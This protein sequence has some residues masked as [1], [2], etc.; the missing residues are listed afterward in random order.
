MSSITVGR[1]SARGRLLFVSSSSAAGPV[2]VSSP[3]FAP[4]AASCY[5]DSHA[6]VTSLP[7]GAY[8]TMRTVGAGTRV[9]D[10]KEHIIRLKDSTRLL[11]PSG[12][13]S[14]PAAAT[15]VTT[16][17]PAENMEELLRLGLREC[18][19]RAIAHEDAHGRQASTQPFK[20]A[21]VDPATVSS[22][23]GAM[24]L[25]A[26]GASSASAASAK[27]ADLAAAREFRLTVVVPVLGAKGTTLPEWAGAEKAEEG[28]LFVHCSELPRPPQSPVSAIVMGHAR[29][30]AA[31]KVRYAFYL[32]IQKKKIFQ[33]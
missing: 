32:P 7:R 29:S 8:T 27:E 33:F 2:S 18:I 20:S 15:A 26:A 23:A 4:S 17:V 14:N 1:I 12:E 13:T 11:T 30:N 6:F 22:A 28:E 9:F 16:V 31:A 10:L 3:G 21:A 25:S 24:S 5:V 19:A